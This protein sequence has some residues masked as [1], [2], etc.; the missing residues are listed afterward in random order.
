MN[1]FHCRA[2]SLGSLVC[3]SVLVHSP[4]GGLLTSGPPSFPTLTKMEREY[5]FLV[6]ILLGTGAMY[7]KPIVAFFFMFVTVCIGLSTYCILDKDSKW[8]MRK[9]GIGSRKID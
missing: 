5:I 6:L 1:S 7:F 2:I 3:S 4:A 8:D 9:G